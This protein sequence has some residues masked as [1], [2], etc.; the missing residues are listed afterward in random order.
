MKISYDPLLGLTLFFEPHE[1]KESIAIL[2][3]LRGKGMDDSA[4]VKFLNH[5]SEM[6]KRESKS[7]Y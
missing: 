7:I 3:Y 4:S 2:E 1:A 5:F 6:I